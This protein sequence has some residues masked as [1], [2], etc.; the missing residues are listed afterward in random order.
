MVDAVAPAPLETALAGTPFQVPA[1]YLETFRWMLLARTLE[2]RIASLYRA[3]QIKGGV[4]LGTGQE[5]LSASLG[6]SLREGDYFG[7]LIRD[8]A[9]RLAFGEAVV[10]VTRT[11]LGS[12]LGPMRARDGNIHRGRPVQ[13][14]FPM[15]SHLGTM[16][17][18]V[19]GALLARRLRGTLQDG[20]GATSIGDG[21]TSTGAFHEGMNL[22]AVE[23]LPLVVVVANNQYAYSTPT[24]RQFACADLL[25]RAAGYGFAGCE[26]DGTDLAAC[27]GV[28]QSAV[29]RARAGKGPQMVVARL[30]RLTGHGEHDDASYVDP[31]LRAS[32]VGGDCLKLARQQILT[33]GWAQA[34]DLEAWRAKCVSQVDAAV[35]TAQSD[36]PPDPEREDWSALSTR[37]LNGPCREP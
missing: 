7:P 25:D 18:V 27:L 3:G 22:A 35:A 11:Y 24:S 12:P 19:A 36:A 17:S 32:A 21:G 13:G 30:L 10:D 29:A 14:I 20:V 26:V 15:V 8:M 16:V 33:R 23:R 37:R 9:G 5:A 4:F 1:A 31:A 6:G 34:A 2:E 28:I